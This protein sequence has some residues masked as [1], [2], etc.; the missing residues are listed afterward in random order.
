METI[1]ILEFIKKKQYQV[2]I[3]VYG[4]FKTIISFTTLEAAQSY[5]GHNYDNKKGLVIIESE[6]KDI[7]IL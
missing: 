6:I 4:G 7:I 2:A 1:D 5:I 3:S